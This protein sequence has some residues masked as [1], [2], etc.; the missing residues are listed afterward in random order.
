M[1][2]FLKVMLFSVIV[3][4]F[5]AG[6]S[7]FG[8]PQIEPA[9]PPQ[10]EVLDLSTMTMDQYIAL[11]DRIYNGKGTCTLCHNELGRAPTLDKMAGVIKD[12]LED[13]DYRGEASDLESY[14]RESMLK[15]SAYVVSGFGKAGTND[16]E[17]PMPDVSSG[18]IGLTDAETDAV[19]AYLQDWGGVDVTVE[20]AAPEDS[21]VSD[22]A[23]GEAETA[24]RAPYTS[25]EDIIAAL[26]CGA[27]HKIADQQG[28]LGPDLL[29]IG[30][31]KDR[32]Y[33]RRALLDP[34]ADV[35]EGYAPGMM[36]PNYGDQLSANEVEMLL[37]YML[38]SG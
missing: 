2:N 36:P 30:K 32:D 21:A 15:P 7:N 5:F 31:S 20:I 3:I 28:M 17:S 27:C 11:G 12:R 22:G 9:P 19:I 29:M 6:Y 35:A 24:E 23:T 38:G 34:N 4:G 8:I 1:A 10:T 14:L 37:E 18:S 16:S 25:A 13:T 26:S 33:L